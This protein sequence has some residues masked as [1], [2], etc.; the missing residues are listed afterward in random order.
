MQTTTRP[1]TH[2][3][4]EYLDAVLHQTGRKSGQ[5]LMYRCV[6]HQERNPSLSINLEKQVYHCFGCQ[7]SGHLSQLLSSQASQ[8][9]NGR[10]LSLR[11]STVNYFNDSVQPGVEKYSSSSLTDLDSVE[12]EGRLHYYS[13]RLLGKKYERLD[14]CGKHHRA[15]ACEDCGKRPAATWFCGTRLCISCRRRQ[16][17]AFF[18]KHK[19]IGEHGGLCLVALPMS[20]NS[21]AEPT[22]MKDQIAHGREQL[23]SLQQE[24]G[25]PWMV[26]FV[27][28]RVHQG[29]SAPV[30]WVLFPGSQQDIE[31]VKFTWVSYG[32]PLLP[33]KDDPLRSLSAHYSNGH[34]AVWQLIETAS[35]PFV[36]TSDDD[37][38]LCYK[39]SSRLRSFE[40]I[41]L[42]QQERVSGGMM[43]GKDRP[44]KG[45]VCPCCGGTRLKPLGWVPSSDVFWVDVDGA[46]VKLY[47]PDKDDPLRKT[48]IPVLEWDRM[49]REEKREAKADR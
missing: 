42:K 18:E 47:L 2:Y 48:G 1:Q 14:N 13:E 20:P 45:K 24:L 17:A 25:I 30:F 6:F 32:H 16:T 46:R 26:Y 35:I 39:A 3:S 40:S 9:I 43:K 23:A 11:T 41:G 37:F 12:W 8:I 33:R 22:D 4:R 31:R 34:N 10:E 28:P 15:N 7:A 29:I 27:Q 36:F 49:S 19:W 21:V 44:K 5:E 38:L